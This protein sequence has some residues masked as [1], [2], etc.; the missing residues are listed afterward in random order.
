[1][2][3]NYH[4]GKSA[5]AIGTLLK[6][7]PRES[8]TLCNKMPGW[9]VTSPEKAKELFETQL[10]QCGVE[11]FD[12]YLCHAISEKEDYDKPYEEFGGYGVLAKEKEAGRIKRLGFSF[13]GSKELFTYVLDKHPWDFVLLQINYIDWVDQEAEFFYKEAERR[14]IPCM[15]MEPLK[16]GELASLTPDANEILEKAAPGKSIASW[17]FRYVG[18]LTNV[19]CVL[20]GMREMEH[21]KDNLKTFG[22]FKPL[23]QEERAALEQA[24]AEYRKYERIGCTACRYCMPCK[25]GVDIPAIFSAY[26]KCVRESNIPDMNGPKDSKFNKKKRA[27]LATYNNMV[28]EGARADKCID[29]GACNGVCPQKLNVSGLISRIKDMV[30]ELEK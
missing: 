24:I 3:W 28:P 29:C 27:F 9:L 19:L 7:Y 8:F 14:G 16:G 1:T 2:A 30:K 22:N 18:S 15:I 6:D 26:N 23:S 11:Y 25:F 21:L 5:E 4:N 17:A 13:H 12:Y 20:S 10:Q